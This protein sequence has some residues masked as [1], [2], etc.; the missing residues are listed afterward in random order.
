MWFDILST[1]WC[2]P[3]FSYGLC[4]ELP[5]HNTLKI[6]RYP[7]FF[8]FRWESLLSPGWAI[9]FSRGLYNHIHNLMF[10][11]KPHLTESFFTSWEKKNGRLFI[12]QTSKFW[13]FSIS[14]KF[15]LQTNQSLI[16]YISL[17]V[18]YYTLQKVAPWHIQHSIYRSLLPDPQVY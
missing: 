17:S 11:Q 2:L 15:C 1:Y 8:F 10:I 3:N 7:F 12:F 18:P 5:Q 14:H 9:S 13:V 16:A 6:L 4:E